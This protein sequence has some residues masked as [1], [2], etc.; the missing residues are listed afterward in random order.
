MT[1]EHVTHNGQEYIE[2]FEQRF[3]KEGQ[4]F[5]D[6]SPFCDVVSTIS[7]T[8]QLVPAPDLKR[9]IT[10]NTQE[11]YNYQFQNDQNMPFD[12]NKYIISYI[13]SK[14]RTRNASDFREIEKFKIH[15]G[16]LQTVNELKPYPYWVEY[17]A[18]QMMHSQY[19]IDGTF[20]L[21]RG[22]LAS[23]F[24]Q[25]PTYTEWLVHKVARTR[26]IRHFAIQQVLQE[27]FPQQFDQT[28]INEI[29]DATGQKLSTRRFTIKQAADIFPS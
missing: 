13:E 14:S 9:A 29:I 10:K 22:K 28:T 27:T 1:I 15:A 8:L 26:K 2:L 20:S 12:G 7:E 24:M 17:V 11:T 4:D 18:T 25:I 21:K 23:K 6:Q 5:Y 3:L 16:I 19:R